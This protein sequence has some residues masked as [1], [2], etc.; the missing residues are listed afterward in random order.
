[1]DD[2]YDNF[3]DDLNSQRYEAECQGCDMWGPVDDIGLCDDWAGKPERDMTRK[4]EWAFLSLPLDALRKSW[5]ISGRILLK[6]M[7]K[8]SNSFAKITLQE[9]GQKEETQA[10]S[11]KKAL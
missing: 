1:M 7:V 9:Q 8:L 4:R 6:S 2:F 5:K 10:V 3:D 11:L